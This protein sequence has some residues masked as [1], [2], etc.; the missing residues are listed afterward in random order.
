MW[1]RPTSPARTCCAEGPR[2]GAAFPLLASAGG[3]ERERVRGG[4]VDGVMRE[5]KREA[6]AAVPG[7]PL[8][9]VIRTEDLAGLSGHDVGEGAVEVPEVDGEP[10]RSAEAASGS[11]HGVAVAGLRQHPGA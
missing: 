8:V 5:G 3:F 4:L 1:S 9:H 7:L 6:R 2:F 11:F 10:L